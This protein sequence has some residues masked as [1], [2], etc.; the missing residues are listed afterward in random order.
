MKC[1]NCQKTVPSDALKCP[2]CNTRI[3]LICKNCHTVNSISDIICKK[4][5]EEILRLCPE[6]SCVN[7]PNAKVCRK[8]GF[9][10]KEPIKIHRIEPKEQSIENADGAKR[11][12]NQNFAKLVFIRFVGCGNF[13]SL[14]FRKFDNVRIIVSA[15]G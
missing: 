11:I 2:H 10:F 7:F 12:V 15:D 5:G 4:C 6:C 13:K 9:E 3:G 14:A 8:C 1:P